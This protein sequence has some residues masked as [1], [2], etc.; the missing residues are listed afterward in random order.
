VQGPAGGA[1]A[2]WHLLEI[3]FWLAAAVH[4][5]PAARQAPD[6]DRDRHSGAVCPVARSDLGLRRPSSRSARGLLRYGAY[7]AG[8]LAKHEI[9]NEPLLA[10]LASVSRPCCSVS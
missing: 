3:A 6:P 2:R 10:L 4:L 9:I 1:L 8:L 7:A 5:L